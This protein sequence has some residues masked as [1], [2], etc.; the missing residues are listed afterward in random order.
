MSANVLYV[1]FLAFCLVVAFGRRTTLYKGN[2]FSQET[3]HVGECE[4]VEGPVAS[5][6]EVPRLRPALHQPHQALEACVNLGEKAE[7]RGLEPRATAA[8]RHITWNA[9]MQKCEDCATRLF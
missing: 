8:H 3:D 6:V 9:Y 1:L 2:C 5:V 7:H 4:G